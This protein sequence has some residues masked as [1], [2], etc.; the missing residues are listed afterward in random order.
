MEFNYWNEVKIPTPPEHVDDVPDTATGWYSIANQKNRD[1][2]VSVYF[3]RE[4]YRPQ[5]QETKEGTLV[6]TGET[7]TYNQLVV[8]LD[9]IDK[10]IK[11]LI[12]EFERSDST[13]LPE[14]IKTNL[15]ETHARK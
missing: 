15:Q 3:H 13:N 9:N 12:D 1:Q 10:L 4:E 7:D 2:A 8:G 6:V 5:E 11:D 14:F